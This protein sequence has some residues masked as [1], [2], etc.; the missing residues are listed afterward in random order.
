MMDEVGLVDVWRLMNPSENDFSFYSNA[1][2]MYSRIDMILIPNVSI[3]RVTKSGIGSIF[4]SDHAPTSVHLSVQNKNFKQ[5]GWKCD[6]SI[7]ADPVFC[8]WAEQELKM[9][10]N[11]NDN[12]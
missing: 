10:I 9:F 3:D 12:N 8:K 4:I 7:L 2:K 1:H 6:R 5:S 11:D